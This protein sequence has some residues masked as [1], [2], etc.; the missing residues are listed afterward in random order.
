[1]FGLNKKE[2]KKLRK[3]D[4]PRK[5]QDFV[6]RLKINFEPRGD[7]CKS[8]RV[9]L[10]TRKAHC[11][12]AA[13]LAALALRLQGHKP[14]LVDLTAHERDFD[15]VIAVFK[16]NGHWGAIS[17]S[18]H[19]V[20]RYRDPIY[21]SLRELI[22]SYFN[23]YFLPTGK[24]SLKSYS[25]P[26]NLSKFDRKGWTISENDVWDIPDALVKAKHHKVLSRSQASMLRKVDM[27]ELDASDIVQFRKERIPRKGEKL[28]GHRVDS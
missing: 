17:K 2:L 27:L 21:K 9:V 8:P 14:L 4:S 22:M 28:I 12:E 5:I 11:I 1:M 3:L 7:T 24:K 23:E 15:H 6:T 18:N 16:K 20:L 19:I 10:R 13:M 25:V 26:V